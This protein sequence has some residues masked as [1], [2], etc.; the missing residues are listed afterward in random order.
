MG[1]DETTGYIPRLITPY[2]LSTLDSV[3]LY[4]LAC[5]GTT[6]VMLVVKYSVGIAA[7]LAGDGHDPPL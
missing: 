3:C 2:Y 5:S 4:V 6:I 1:R 7:C